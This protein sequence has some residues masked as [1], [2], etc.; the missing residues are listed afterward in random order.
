ML[1]L[2]ID[3]FPSDVR[4]SYGNIHRGRRVKVSDGK[5]L[6]IARVGHNLQRLASLGWVALI[7]WFRVMIRC[8]LT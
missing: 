7:R 8:T 2:N 5:I 4:R 3:S 1:Y 6:H